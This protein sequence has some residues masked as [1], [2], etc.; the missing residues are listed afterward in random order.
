MI[1]AGVDCLAQNSD[2]RVKALQGE[3][4]Y[5][6]GQDKNGSI[7]YDYSK[8]SDRERL[9]QIIKHENNNLFIFN[10]HDIEGF[11]ERNFETGTFT[12]VGDNY[13][14]TMRNGTA[15]F[16]YSIQGNILTCGRDRKSDK[17]A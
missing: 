1:L 13:I 4:L 3:W 14:A 2:V 8:S 6:L 5:I 10:P 7:V 17:Q 12:I 16:K 15:T 9:E 11:H